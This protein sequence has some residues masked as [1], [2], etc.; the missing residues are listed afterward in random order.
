MSEKANTRSLN[1]M[2]NARSVRPKLDIREL[3][4]QFGYI[5][6]IFFAQRALSLYTKIFVAVISK[7]CY[8]SVDF[9]HCLF[10]TIAFTYV[11]RRNKIKVDVT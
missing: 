3:R 6:F 2:Q 4:I 10:T 7:S 5:R 11:Q 9:N 8:A 1:P